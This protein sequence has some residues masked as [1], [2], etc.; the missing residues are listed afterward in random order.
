MQGSV[1]TYPM[2]WM[3]TQEMLEREIVKVKTAKAEHSG[4]RAKKWLS[5]WFGD[6]E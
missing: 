6:G 4:G 3:V 1:D 2:T 5:A